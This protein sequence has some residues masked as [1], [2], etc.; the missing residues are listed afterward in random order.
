MVD[1]IGT[2]AGKIWAYLNEN[3]EATVSKLVN[4]LDETERIVVMGIGWLAREEQLVFTTKGRFNYISL[5]G[6]QSEG[7]RV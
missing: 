7:A 1:Q 5:K 2:V 6:R 4:E 3:N